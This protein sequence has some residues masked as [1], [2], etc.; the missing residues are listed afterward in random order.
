MG[1]S[2]SGSPQN[3]DFFCVDLRSPPPDCCASGHFAV[4]QNYFIV[5]TFLE[6]EKGLIY[7]IE[8]Y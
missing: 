4:K 2:I 6:R 1:R 5:G 7:I 8:G 3:N